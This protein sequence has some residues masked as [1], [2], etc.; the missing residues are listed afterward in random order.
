MSKILEVLSGKKTY[1]VAAVIALATYAELV[2]WIDQK[3]FEALIGFL[4]AIGLYTVREA[5]KKLE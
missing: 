2:G 1:I 4:G 3:T 5:I